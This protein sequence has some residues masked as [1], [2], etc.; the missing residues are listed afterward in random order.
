MTTVP[1]VKAKSLES[2]RETRAALKNADE[3][4]DTEL[5]SDGTAVDVRF[6]SNTK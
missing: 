6:V 5:R 2:R 3:Q 4:E 1:I